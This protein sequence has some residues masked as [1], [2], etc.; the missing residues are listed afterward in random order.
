V[1]I[2]P[3]CFRLLLDVQRAKSLGRS[4]AARFVPV[5]ADQDSG[6]RE[7]L[8][9]VGKEMVRMRIGQW[10]SQVP[11]KATRIGPCLVVYR[12][13]TKDPASALSIATKQL[14]AKV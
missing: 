13:V 4:H 9:V 6:L 10:R 14:P 2:G 8:S 3:G 11:Q 1:A 7:L 12:R 5:C